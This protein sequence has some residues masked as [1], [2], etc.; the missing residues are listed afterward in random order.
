MGR[1]LAYTSPGRGHL[2]PAVPILDV[3]QR[4]A[5]ETVGTGALGRGWHAARLRDP[6]S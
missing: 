3:S 4:H 6:P 2:F 5:S 1:I